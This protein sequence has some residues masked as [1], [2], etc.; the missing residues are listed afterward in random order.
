MKSHF[1]KIFKKKFRGK[2]NFM[3][4][5]NY[6]NYLKY[7][8]FISIVRSF[9]KGEVTRREVF[10]AIGVLVAIRLAIYVGYQHL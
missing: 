1:R 5:K 8:R 9:R 4:I 3:E 7:F 6:V 10:I 2:K